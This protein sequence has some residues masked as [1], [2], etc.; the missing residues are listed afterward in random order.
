MQFPVKVVQSRQGQARVRDLV[1]LNDL[2]NE[3]K[4]HA[5]FNLTYVPLDLVACGR[6]GVTDASLGG[7][8]RFGQATKGERKT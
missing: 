6:V 4:T 7:V 3:T 2:I 5:D 8:D 1:R